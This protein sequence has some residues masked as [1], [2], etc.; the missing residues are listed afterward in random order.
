MLI[1][2]GAGFIGSNLVGE[3]HRR[4]AEI[5]VFDN[6]VSTCSLRLIERFLGGVRFV[7]GDIR[8]KEDFSRLPAGPYDR[9]YHLAASFANELSMEQPDLDVR[10]NVEGTRNV[11]E[12]AR[13]AGCGLLVYTGSSSS[14]GDVPVPMSEDGPLRPQT[15]YAASKL[16]GEQLV[17]GSSLPFAILRLFNV[18][19][20]G[21]SPGKYRNAVPNMFA[22]LNDPEGLLRVFGEDA[23]RDFTYVGDLMRVLLDADRARGRVMNVASG[24]ET[25][26][27]DLAR[28]IL[29]IRGRP[30]ERMVLGPRRDWDRVVRRRADVTHLRQSYGEVPATPIDEGLHRTFAWLV[31]SGYVR[32][33]AT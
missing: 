10:T 14:Y 13:R 22:A 26:I 24:T 31:E 1:T 32:E 11:V 3:W 17:R 25:P 33:G 7:H 9:V 6:L 21:D 20:P 23:T 28:A 27:V 18:Y 2:G 8:A 30:L 19:G 4:G 12:H 29:A 5:T 15:P 16:A